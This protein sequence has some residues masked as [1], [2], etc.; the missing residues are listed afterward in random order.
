MP[1]RASACVAALLFACLASAGS[2]DA[3]TTA[4]TD[5][6]A[7]GDKIWPFDGLAA[8]FGKKEAVVD[9]EAGLRGLPETPAAAFGSGSLGADAYLAPDLYRG[10]RRPLI[11]TKL[12]LR[13][14]QRVSVKQLAQA[15][16]ERACERR[17][18]R[19]RV[20]SQRRAWTARALRA[21]TRRALCVPRSPPCPA[22]SRKAVEAAKAA[23]AAEQRAA[24]A[25]EAQKEAEQAKTGDPARGTDSFDKK[26]L[27]KERKQVRSAPRRAGLW[28]GTRRRGG[29]GRLG[30][31]A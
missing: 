15:A 6:A 27:A 13:C 8:L 20:L 21:H 17:R 9:K 24:A 25:A 10:H 2:R 19:A 11:K 14:T 26:R 1:G 7:A 5:A 3:A 4:R 22:G 28:R 12:C 31:G 23:S 18:R 29:G 16:A 30:H